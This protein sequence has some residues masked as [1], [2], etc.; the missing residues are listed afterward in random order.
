M[1]QLRCIL[2]L[3]EQRRHSSVSQDKMQVEVRFSR[4]MHKTRGKAT[5]VKRGKDTFVTYAAEIT[6][7]VEVQSNHTPQK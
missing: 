4:L 3:V 5:L 2:L 6:H 7:N 1:Q